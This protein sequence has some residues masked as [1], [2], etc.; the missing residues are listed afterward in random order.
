M[1]FHPCLLS[2]HTL[3]NKL[4]SSLS[5][6]AHV[7]L[8]VKSHTSTSGT[9]DCDPPSRNMMH[10]KVVLAFVTSHIDYCSSLPAGLPIKTRDCSMFKTVLPGFSLLHL[11]QNTSA[12]SSTHHWLVYLQDLLI[13]QSAP[14][15]AGLAAPMS[16]PLTK[17]AN[18]GDHA[19][20][21]VL[22]CG[23]LWKRSGLHT[24]SMLLKH[25]LRIIC[26]ALAFTNVLVFIYVLDYFAPDLTSYIF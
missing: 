2:H 10:K 23:I 18:M 19:I 17:L 13:P 16:L 8:S 11:N 21:L 24:H 6:E 22:I 12:Q 1:E 15:S 3:Q 20:S 9:P 4:D 5:F 7:K 25:V 14:Y 26:F